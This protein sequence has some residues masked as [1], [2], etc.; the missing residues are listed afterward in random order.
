M[1]HTYLQLSRFCEIKKGLN[2]YHRT[3]KNVFEDKKLF[4]NFDDEDV[5]YLKGFFS[6]LGTSD[7]DG[8]IVNCNLYKKLFEKKHY[9]LE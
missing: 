7:T 8:Q 2:D 4:N 6:M 3:L 9:Q 1:C 5:E